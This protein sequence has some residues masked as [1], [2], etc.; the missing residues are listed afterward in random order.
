M[1]GPR[2]YLLDTS[3][4][5]PHLTSVATGLWNVIRSTSSPNEVSDGQV[6]QSS[7]KRT[8]SPILFRTLS[9]SENQLTE[10]SIGFAIPI[11]ELFNGGVVWRGVVYA[12]LMALGKCAT[13]LW[14][15]VP[16]AAGRIIAKIKKSNSSQKAPLSN[17][18]TDTSGTDESNTSSVAASPL[19]PLDRD[20]INPVEIPHPL[21]KTETSNDPEAQTSPS[22]TH[23]PSRHGSFQAAVL[24]SVAMTTRGE[25]GFLI[26][27]VAQSSGILVPSEIY[28]IVMWAIVL[29][30]LAGP[31]GV[32]IITRRLAKMDEARRNQ[33][34]GIWA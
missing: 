20:V 8:S 32:G 1:Q 27:A 10:A 29:C 22:S 15:I 6:L 25:I 28:L 16:P 3:L 13:G 34:L 33:I 14:L 24:L 12:I 4:V 18:T 7:Y 9:S 19:V 2:F 23:S 17:D 11:R 30:T 26:A 5:S 21:K 31:V